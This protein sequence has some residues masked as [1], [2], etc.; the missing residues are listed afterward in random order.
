MKFSLSYITSSMLTAEDNNNNNVLVFYVNGREISEPKPDPELTLLYYLRTVLGLTG[1]KLACGEGGCGA[2]T[3]MLSKYDRLSSKV[4]HFSAYSC[5]TPLCYVHGLAVTTVE[6]LGS[7]RTKLHPIQERIALSHGTQCGFC[8]PGM[9]MSMYAMLRNNPNPSLKQVEGAID[10][11]LC[12]CTG[13]RPIMDGFKSFCCGLEAD[14]C[15]NMF[16]KEGTIVVKNGMLPIDGL[17]KLDPTQELIFPPKLMI[18]DQSS[19]RFSNGKVTWLTPISLKEL[20]EMKKNHLDAKIVSG[21]TR[22]GIEIRFKSVS[23]S[24]FISTS[25]VRSEH[26]F[27]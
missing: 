21:N 23:Y 24:V 2:C 16:K 17:T 27:N 20:L 26:N 8:T 14:C 3:V 13:Y 11:N 19:T 5:L 6:G 22:I 25:E 9:V 1:T 7:T 15:Q 12:R 10:G 18:S 4:L